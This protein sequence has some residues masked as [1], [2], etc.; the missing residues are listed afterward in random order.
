[1][2]TLVQVNVV[3][4]WNFRDRQGAEDARTIIEPELLC[5]RAV[6]AGVT[7]I[8]FLDEWSLVASL[9]SGCVIM[10]QCSNFD[11]VSCICVDI[12]VYCN[13]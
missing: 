11:E 9:E 1:M 13:I 6:G 4:M 5:K 10:L 2:G 7:D 8:C 3:C 12:L